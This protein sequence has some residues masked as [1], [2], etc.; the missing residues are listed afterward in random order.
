MQLKGKGKQQRS[1]MQLKGQKGRQQM[2]RMQLQG[3]KGKQQR[4]G[5]SYSVGKRS[6]KGLNAATGLERETVKGNNFAK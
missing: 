5:C 4:P 1:R 2:S 3:L 6:N